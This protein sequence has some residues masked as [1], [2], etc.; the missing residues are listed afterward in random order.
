METDAVVDEKG[1]QFALNISRK[2]KQS[3]TILIWWTF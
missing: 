3:H 2:N 1:T